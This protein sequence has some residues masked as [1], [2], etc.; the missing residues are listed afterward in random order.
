MV[1]MPLA[2]NA[3]S[4][5][6]KAA[7]AKLN[8]VRA[9]LVSGKTTLVKLASNQALTL[10]KKTINQDQLSGVMAAVLPTLK[11]KAISEVVRMPSGVALVQVD[12]IMPAKSKP[13]A[14]VKDNI[15]KRIVQQKISTQFANLSNDL[16]N[17]TFTNPTSLAPAA[18]SMGIKVV[19]SDFITKKGL[20]KGILSNK[21]ILN[22]VFSKEVLDQGN[23][24][25]PLS[26]KDGSVIVVRVANKQAPRVLSLAE[27]SAKVKAQLQKSRSD[28]QAGLVAYKIQQAIAAG[29]TKAQIM[30]KFKVKYVSYNNI[31]AQNKKIPVAILREVF[32]LKPTQDAK[33]PVSAAVLLKN[34]N[35]AII[36]LL[37]VKLASANAVPAAEV[38]VLKR[39]MQNYNAR[40]E[41]EFLA[42]SAMSHAKIKN[43]LEQQ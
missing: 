21:K 13:L 35:Y 41:Y 43:Y 16:S 8:T 39:E 24:S 36:K 20:A 4:D 32:Q 29:K 17:L 22:A 30:A 2:Q 3:G 11:Q 6:V 40:I 10:S 38:K 19:T 31:A 23:N 37:G 34:G 1:M 25:Y 15:K 28:S 42:K 27:V 7:M 26:L 33:H 9:N 5:T 18:K 14:Q 12:E